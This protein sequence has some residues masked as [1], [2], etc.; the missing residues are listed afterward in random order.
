MQNLEERKYLEEEL[1]KLLP[2]IKSG[3]IYL[4]L[5]ISSC[6][7]LKKVGLLTELGDSLCLTLDDVTLH[8]NSIGDPLDEHQDTAEI[9]L[10]DRSFRRSSSFHD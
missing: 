10:F 4:S 8:F 3:K 2:D 9:Y 7:E 1:R 5:L 6:N